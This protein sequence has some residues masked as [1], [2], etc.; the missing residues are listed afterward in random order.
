MFKYICLL[1]RRETGIWLC[2]RCRLPYFSLNAFDSPLYIH[3]PSSFL[4]ICSFQFRVFHLL[5]FF[6]SIR[7]DYSCSDHFVL[8]VLG[9][10]KENT[11]PAAALEG[12]SSLA[13]AAA[14]TPSVAVPKPRLAHG[15]RFHPTDEELVV[16]FLH[17]KVCR[18]PFRFEA[19][20]EIDIYKSEPWELQGLSF[21]L[22]IPN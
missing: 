8:C 6:H 20:A 18:K 9:M 4:P 7:F 14:T 22:L 15:F 10:E 1:N 11:Q 3:I 5:S 19:I 13:V 17:R 16:Y 21:I 12:D 2:L